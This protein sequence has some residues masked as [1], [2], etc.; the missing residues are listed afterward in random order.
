M[1]Y[2]H[3]DRTGDIGFRDP[4]KSQCSALARRPRWKWEHNRL[5]SQRNEPVKKEPAAE[6]LH[7]CYIM[8][9]ISSI[10]CSEASKVLDLP[11]P[12]FRF[13]PWRKLTIMII[14]VVRTLEMGLLC[15][16]LASWEMQVFSF[17]PIR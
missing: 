13:R 8:L 6:E 9:I 14:L 11:M 1:L 16:L 2:E 15:A 17:R 12:R 7:L 10:A 3:T 5:G 4:W